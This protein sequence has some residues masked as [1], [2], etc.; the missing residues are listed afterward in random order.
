MTIDQSLPSLRLLP[1]IRPTTWTPWLFA[2]AV[3]AVPL[4]FA[5]DPSPAAAPPPPN[6]LVIDRSKTALIVVDMQ[7]DFGAK[8]GMFDQL[9]IDRSG[10]QQAVAPTARVIAAAH[11]AGIKVIYL[12]MAF[13]PDL[14]DAGPDDSPNRIGHLRAGAGKPVRAPDGTESRILIRDTWNTAVLDALKPAPGDLQ[15]Y[16][17]RFSGFFE[18]DLNAVLKGLGIRQLIVTGC[19]TS[20]CVESTIRDAMFLDY[21]CVLLSDCTAEPVGSNYSRSN[22]DASL[23]L[24]RTRLGGTVSDSESFLKA[25]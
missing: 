24:I 5:A 21:T 6:P 20:V 8:G 10:I 25:L 9:G 1:G 4:A 16:K 15:I 22:Y 7:N 23:L 18:T 13:R 12:K 14:S 19:T 11:Q 17:H 3:A 2:M